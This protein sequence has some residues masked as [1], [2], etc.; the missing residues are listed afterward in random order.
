MVDMPAINQALAIPLQ[1]NR[2]AGAPARGPANSAPMADVASKTS[3]RPNRPTLTVPATMLPP[4]ITRPMP[5]I[6]RQ[7]KQASPASGP[8]P[9]VRI[10]AAD[11]VAAR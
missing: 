7:T 8:A 9:D 1:P 5:D 4:A 11:P 6:Q 3:G 2:P 10:S